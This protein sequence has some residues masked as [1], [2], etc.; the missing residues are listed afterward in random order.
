MILVLVEILS[1]AFLAVSVASRLQK[2]DS[3][4]RNDGEIR[5]IITDKS[6]YVEGE[7]IMVTA[8]SPNPTDL[9]SIGLIDAVPARIRS[10]YIGPYPGIANTHMNGEGSGSSFDMRQAYALSDANAQSFKDIPAGKYVIYMTDSSADKSSMYC[11]V[12]IT[13]VAAQE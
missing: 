11:F 9:V 5:R 1:C 13:V 6:V 2:D 12:V 4:I 10:R 3:Y 8:W 7:P